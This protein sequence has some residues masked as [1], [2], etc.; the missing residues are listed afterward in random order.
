MTPPSSGVAALASDV[1][2]SR[3]GALD[4]VEQALARLEHDDDLGAATQILA[5]EARFRARHLDERMARGDDD[6][7]LAGVPFAIKENICG[8]DGRTTCASRLLAE[9]RAGYDA[10]AVA[11]LV[12]A[13]AIPVA[14]AN[15]DEFGMGSS[16]ETSAHGPVRHPESPAH[17]AGGSSGGSAALVASG[18]V[19][20]ALGS[21][22]GGSVRQPAAFCGVVG[23]KPS[24]GR[25]S[26][27]GLAAFASSLDV[28]GVLARG[29]DDAFDV[30]REIAGHDPRDAQ[31][32]VL[33]LELD[34]PRDVSRVG[35]VRGLDVEG[36]PIDERCADGLERAI[37]ALRR[38]GIEVSDAGMPL[39]ELAVSIY[40]VVGHAEASTNLARYDAARFGRRSRSD[41]DFDA[42]VRA[43]RGAGLGREVKRRVLLG[44]WLLSAGRGSRLYERA[45]AARRRVSA[46][47][48]GLFA[49]HDL[50][51]MPT[52]PRTAFRPG[53]LD[54]DA[55]R[56]F[57]ADGFN[58]LASLGGHP[59]ISLPVPRSRGELPLGVQLVAPRFDEPTL[60]RG[61]RIL[62]REGFRPLDLGAAA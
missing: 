12:D 22:T 62:E 61:A 49:R 42:L 36:A 1:R 48:D 37:E 21:D 25:V 32:S 20:F 9:F 38:R 14:R 56:V 8:T 46:A 4:L 18:A 53:E 7:S 6:P 39:T 44:A 50:L 52:T 19:P 35:V 55:M 47:I 58:V 5:D 54:G 57:S 23:L 31:T 15:A 34:A 11:R 28:I 59:A 43:S 51:L 60:R 24:Y 17:L 13:G 33:P 41:G 40:V 26:R 10:T 30:L 27:H 29:V 45:L 3:V 2:A 16:S